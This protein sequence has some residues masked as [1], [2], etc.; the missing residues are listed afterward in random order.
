MARR[1]AQQDRRPGLGTLLPQGIARARPLHR[2]VRVALLLFITVSALDA[3]RLVL[4]G[5]GLGFGDR[6]YEL[7]LVVLETATVAVLA[8]RSS[9][10]WLP[11]AAL[12]VLLHPQTNP[13]SYMVVIPLV[14]AF[15]AYGAA[16]PGLAAAVGAFLVWQTSWAV[17]VSVVGPQFL[18]SYVPLTLVLLLPGLVLRALSAQQELDRV[19]IA[20]GQ[21]RTAHALEQQRLEL[22]RE[23][24]DI[25]AHDL[26]LIAMQARSGAYSRDPETM[27]EALDVVGD[28]SRAALKDLR[29]L[30]GIMRV[31]PGAGLAQ[32]SSAAA[33]VD[34]GRGLE[35]AAAALREV[36]FRTDT[37]VRGDL[38]RIPEG[39][40][41]TVQRVLQEGATNIMKHAPARTSCVLAV[42]VDEADVVVEV[43][44]AAG[45]GSGPGLPASGYGLLGLRERVQLLGGEL[46]AGPAD[47]GWRVGARIPLGPAAV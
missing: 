30:L 12:L 20:A 14:L 44:N 4:T 39:V 8:L 18:W 40:R 21:E 13:G 3:V 23:L 27:K 1:A 37:R 19:E 35:E 16:L 7:L 2:W 34:T 42:Q 41:P 5:P 10:T 17:N 6:D 28:S 15:T 38:A 46:A 31:E 43:H 45:P 26:T 36:G 24:H 11:L 9:W 47:G 22:A 33:A 29:R 25:V 32:D